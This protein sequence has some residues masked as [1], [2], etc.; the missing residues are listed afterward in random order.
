MSKPK[1]SK[2]PT[3]WHAV[4]AGTATGLL[5]FIIG[6][7]FFGPTPPFGSFRDVLADI[8]S[9]PM[10]FLC[11]PSIAG[12][13]KALGKKTFKAMWRGAIIGELILFGV[14]LLF[15]MFLAS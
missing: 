15:F 14:M 4:G 1:N 12:A 9:L 8:F 7:L 6:R 11:L 5:S 10:L 13:Y 2:R 3:A